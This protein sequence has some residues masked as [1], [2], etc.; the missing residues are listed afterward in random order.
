[1][2]CQGG[3][4]CYSYTEIIVV[5]DCRRKS[6]LQFFEVA[7]GHDAIFVR[8]DAA[9]MTRNRRGFE[10]VD[11]IDDAETE[12]GLDNY[13]NW[14]FRITNDFEGD[15]S[16]LSEIVEFVKNLIVS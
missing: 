9:L 2:V 4:N 5:A 12:C 15:I 13:A 7:F 16:E 14:H 3:N 8:I 6:D 1:M 10:F 11:G